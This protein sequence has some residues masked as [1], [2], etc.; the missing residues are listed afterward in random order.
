MLAGSGAG[1][2][3]LADDAHAGSDRAKPASTVKPASCK[4]AQSEQARAQAQAAALNPPNEVRAGVP[5]VPQ[6]C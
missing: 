4:Q 5:I 6:Q 2:D 3:L 1:A